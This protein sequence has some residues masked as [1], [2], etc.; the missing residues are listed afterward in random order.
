MNVTRLG[1]KFGG[2]DDVAYLFNLLF[3]IP[4]CWKLFL[5]YL[6]TMEFVLIIGN[7]MPGIVEQVKAENGVLTVRPRNTRLRQTH[8][9][10]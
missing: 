6:S 2:H 1:R 10:C 8:E 7:G 3:R 5:H 4:K 9:I